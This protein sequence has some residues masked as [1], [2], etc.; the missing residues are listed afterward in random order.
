MPETD[1]KFRLCLKLIKTVSAM[2]E[3]DKNSFGYA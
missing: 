2:P 3:T 1:K